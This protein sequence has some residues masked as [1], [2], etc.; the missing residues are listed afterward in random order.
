MAPDGGFEVFHGIQASS[1]VTY[2]PAADSDFKDPD[3]VILELWAKPRAAELLHSVQESGEGIVTSEQELIDFLIT[4]IGPVR[5]LRTAPERSRLLEEK[6]RYVSDNEL[7]DGQA[8]IAHQ[9]QVE[10]FALE[11]L[12]QN[13]DWYF[14]CNPNRSNN[15]IAQENIQSFTSKVRAI[16]QNERI[17]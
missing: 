1:A 16:V 9:I 8:G 6:L 5:R 2:L 12:F 10:R 4:R 15:R 11:Q 17:L 13:I 14:C 7:S 3:Q